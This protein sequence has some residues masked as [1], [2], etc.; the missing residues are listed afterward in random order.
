MSGY[1]FYLNYCRVNMFDK[2]FLYISPDTFL[3][4]RVW[5]I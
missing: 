5:A 3:Y 1:K 2:Y 4:V